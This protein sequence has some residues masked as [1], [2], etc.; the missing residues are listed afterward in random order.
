[1]RVG[2]KLVDGK[3]TKE[4]YL[5][6]WLDSDHSNL[7]YLPKAGYGDQTSPEQ[8]KKARYMG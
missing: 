5:Q 3:I 2:L 8:R 1:M 4:R 6:L 7:T